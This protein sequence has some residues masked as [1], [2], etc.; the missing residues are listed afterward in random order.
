MVSESELHN[1]ILAKWFASKTNN[2]KDNKYFPDIGLLSKNAKFVNI[3]NPQVNLHLSH[4]K[5][6]AGK[7]FH[8]FK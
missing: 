4:N 2:N 3:L 1:S 5:M 6:F 8:L 7:Y